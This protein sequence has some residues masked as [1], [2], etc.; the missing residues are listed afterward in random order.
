M[1][2]SKNPKIVTSRACANDMREL[3][4]VA[5]ELVDAEAALA[6]ARW[7]AEQTGRTVTVHDADGELLETFQGATKN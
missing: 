5:L 3:P 6:L 1:T 4:M 7:M 2:K